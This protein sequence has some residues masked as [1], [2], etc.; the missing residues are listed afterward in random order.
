MAPVPSP[1]AGLGE[2]F[3]RPVVRSLGGAKSFDR[4]EDYAARGRVTQLT[5]ERSSAGAMVRG[6]AP[7]RVQLWCEDGKP[8]FSCTCPVGAEGSFCKHAVAL[9]LVATDPAGGGQPDDEPPVDL[10]AYLDGL[11][12]E[13]LV[14]LVLELADANELASA[15]LRLEAARTVPGPLPLRAFTEAIDEA[16]ATEGFIS[17]REAY[18]YAEGIDAVIASLRDLLRDGHA[19]AVIALTEHALKEA[20]E[21]VGSV[22][23]S[24]GHLGEIAAELQSLHLEACAQAHPDPVVLAGRLFDWELHGGDLEV[25]SGAAATYA[26]VL[27]EKG[28]AAYRRLAESAWDRLPRLAPGAGR[29][30]DGER[31]RIADMM[32]A[33]AEA[34]GD[35]DQVVEVLAKDQ[36]SP[37]AFVRIAE[38]LRAAGRFADALQW[39]ERGLHSF[40]A[41]ADP[42]LVAVAADEY[43]RAGMSEKAV[44]LSWQVF[45]ARPGPATYERL[46]A[47]AIKAGIWAAW[48]PQALELLRAKVAERAQAARRSGRGGSLPMWASLADASDLVAVFLFERDLEQAWTE[49]KAGGCSPALW[50]ELARG[51]E[52]EHPADAIP[53]FEERVERLIGAKRNDAYHEA[54]DLMAHVGK[55][56][57]EAAQPEAFEPYAAGVRARHKAKRNLVKLLDARHW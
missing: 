54:V 25:F 45:D 55:L 8:R 24:D 47:Q 44:Q 2:V 37:Y 7:Y 1:E 16:F 34:G 48:R 14:D 26:E 50:L 40:E 3:T 11:A 41:T 39:A 56:M 6:T 12:R 43:H 10:R 17:Y 13:R 5:K 52:G 27:G 32:E 23:D 20:E 36:S 49:A 21:A 33:L 4:G 22:D 46:A 38:R 19:V 42:R 29:S 9:A 30:F 31:H 28:I 18:A 57:R 15:R 51:R 53:I 35:V